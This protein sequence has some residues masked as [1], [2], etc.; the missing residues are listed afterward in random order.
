[1]LKLKKNDRKSNG[2]HNLLPLLVPMAMFCVCMLALTTDAQAM[3]IGAVDVMLVANE[4]PIKKKFEDELEKIRKEK[5]EAFQ[6][7]AKKQFGVKNLDELKGEQKE[8]FQQMFM[9][10]NEKFNDEMKKKYDENL[11]IIEG[12]ILKVVQSIAQKKKL[13]YVLDKSVMLFGGIDITDEAVSEIKK[14]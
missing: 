12:D 2:H 4:H 7:K 11:K 9:D 1:M 3:E 8:Q 10:E 13:T 5:T 6:E 14:K